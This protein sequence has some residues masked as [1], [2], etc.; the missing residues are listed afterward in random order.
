LF[1][2]FLKESGINILE[3]DKGILKR[4]LSHL[5]TEKKLK[6]ASESPIFILERNQA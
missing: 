6:Q 3:M 5:S 4:Y 1:A 2:G